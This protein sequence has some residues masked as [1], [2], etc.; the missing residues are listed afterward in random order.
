[1]NIEDLLPECHIHT[2]SFIILFRDIPAQ[3]KYYKPSH[4]IYIGFLHST[5]MA[6]TILLLKV[7]LG[8]TKL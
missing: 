7:A 6:Y 4:S 1:M 2:Y 5:T 3:T 8:Y